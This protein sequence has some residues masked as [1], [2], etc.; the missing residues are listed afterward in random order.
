MRS[1]R[2][3]VEK[4]QEEFN[5]TDGNEISSVEQPE[6]VSGFSTHAP[7]SNFAALIN[8]SEVLH[9]ELGTT[10]TTEYITRFRD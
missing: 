4:M 8:Q 10:Q 2:N 9:R 5:N 7:F 3:S 1:L 6:E